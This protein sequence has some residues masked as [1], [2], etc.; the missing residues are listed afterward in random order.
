MT[1]LLWTAPEHLRQDDVSRTGSQKGDVYSYAIVLYEILQRNG[2]FGNSLEEPKGNDPP[3]PGN[4]YS[5]AE[6]RN[7]DKVKLKKKKGGHV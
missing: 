6:A 7:L 5:Y 3:A 1:G 4:V 2:P